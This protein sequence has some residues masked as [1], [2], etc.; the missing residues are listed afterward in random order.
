PGVRPLIGALVALPEPS[1]A[2]GAPWAAPFSLNWTVPVGV[3]A[4]GASNA[5]EAVN[6]TGWPCTIG[7]FWVIVVV[8]LALLTSWL[9]LPVLPE[10]LSSP[11]Y[12]AE[13]AWLPTVRAAV[14]IWAEPAPAA[15]VTGTVPS[16]VLPSKNSTD[17]VGVPAPG[18]VTA[19]V[20]VNVTSWPNTD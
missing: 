18:L 12:T 20:A 9:V 13:M 14:S 17:P 19:R 10:K 15:G 1:S 8:L 2:T 4:P 7:P 3:P 16:D 5:T 11:E 6:V